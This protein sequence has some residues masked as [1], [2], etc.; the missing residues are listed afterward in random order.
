MASTT[1]QPLHRVGTANNHPRGSYKQQAAKPHARSTL[2]FLLPGPGESAWPPQVAMKCGAQLHQQV[3]ET[4]RQP[5]CYNAYRLASQAI[6]PATLQSQASQQ[7]QYMPARA[8][9]LEAEAAAAA[10]PARSPGDGDG[11]PGRLGGLTR[12]TAPKLGSAASKC[13]GLASAVC[14]P[15]NGDA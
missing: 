9:G 5:C 13:A 10:A 1:W 3:S 11:S 15:G 14:P 12:A 8:P 7:P 2:P 6:S 4:A